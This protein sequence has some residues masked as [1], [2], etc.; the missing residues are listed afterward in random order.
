MRRKIQ[1][2]SAQFQPDEALES[3]TSASVDEDAAALR[4]LVRHVQMT[5]P[6]QVGEEEVLLD[7]AALGDRPSEDRLVAGHLSMV[8]RLAGERGDRG[9]SAADL[10]QEGSIG[11]V[12]AVREFANSGES[13]FATFAEAKVAAQMDQAIAV[14]IRARDQYD[15][16]LPGYIASERYD[17]LR[18]DPRSAAIVESVLTRYAILP[19]AHK[20][21]RAGRAA[22]RGR[23]F[24]IAWRSD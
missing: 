12:K 24:G 6:V 17:R 7:R 4:D 10:V 18:N 16:W 11:L 20:R 1:A 14:L 9:L 13:N 15:P 2:M 19:R 23:S 22:W 8:I 3:S 21:K 5:R